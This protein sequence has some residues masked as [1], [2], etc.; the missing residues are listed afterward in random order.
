MVYRGEAV[1][2]FIGS[3]GTR[4]L[5]YLDEHESR[6]LRRAIAEDNQRRLDDAMIQYGRRVVF[7]N[8][9]GDP[10]ERH[11]PGNIRS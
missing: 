2:I 9:E 8:G 6:L 1:F 7:W 4:K 5:R 10:L 3:E 11:L